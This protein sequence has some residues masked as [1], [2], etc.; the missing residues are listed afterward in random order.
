MTDLDLDA[1]REWT[2]RQII[3][4]AA[5]RTQ[6]ATAAESRRI[7]KRAYDRE[8]YRAKKAARKAATT[9]RTA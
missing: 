1:I 8:R 6:Q 7:R 9:R 3:A 4:N 5:Y 2:T